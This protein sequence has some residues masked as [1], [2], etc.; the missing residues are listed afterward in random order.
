[1]PEVT[2][3]ASKAKSGTHISGTPALGPLHTAMLSPP[4]ASLFTSTLTLLTGPDVRQPRQAKFPPR[5]PDL[6]EAP[7]RLVP[8]R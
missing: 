1:M 4:R 3:L 5:D 6:A 2:Q 8:D 7:E